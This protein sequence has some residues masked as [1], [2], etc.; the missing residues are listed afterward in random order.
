MAKKKIHLTL[1]FHATLEVDE[2]M[3][4]QIAIDE[5]SSE[6]SYD[7]P[8]TDNVEVT[9]TSWEETDVRRVE[10]EGDE[11]NT[12]VWEAFGSSYKLRPFFNTDANTD[13]IDVSYTDNDYIGEIVGVT[14]PDMNDA[15]EVRKFQLT[16]EAWLTDNE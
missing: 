1:I 2:K 16:L 9:D 14:L 8:S 10:R 4:T 11:V 13:C 12:K 5:F 15:D 3:D 6:C 7:F